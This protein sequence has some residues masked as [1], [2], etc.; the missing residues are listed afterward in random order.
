MTTPTIQDP[1]CS[2]DEYTTVSSIAKE[3]LRYIGIFRTPPTPQIFEVW[4]R[5]VEGSNDEFRSEISQLLEDGDALCETRLEDVYQRYFGSPKIV[6]VNESISRSLVAQIDGLQ[7]LLSQQQSAGD[8]F[9]SSVESANHDLRVESITP[10]AIKKCLSAVLAC[11]ERMQAQV[12]QT[13]AQLEQSQRQVN[14]LRQ[15]LVT[16]QKALMTDPL[17]GIGNRRFFDTMMMQAF[18][19]SSQR[20]MQLALVLFDLDKF[21][22]INDSF[23]H[24]AGDEV[25]RFVAS[26]IQRLAADASISRIG[27]DEFALVL[28][29]DDVQQVTDLCETIREFFASETLALSTTGECLGQQTLSIGVSLLRP[30]DDR[31]SWYGRADKLLYAAKDAGRNRIMLERKFPKR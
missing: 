8:E 15:D 23:G 21:K 1:N 2:T 14:Q 11:N 9:E 26:E 22:V 12:R 6:E 20:E 10:A 16:S 19:A 30:D 31:D 17:T 24:S 27:G 28:S 4:Y 13:R 3:A 18:D 25:L 29:I 7:T 5:Y